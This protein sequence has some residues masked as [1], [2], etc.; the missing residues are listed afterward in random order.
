VHCSVTQRIPAEQ[1]VL[2][3]DYDN[4]IN[5]YKLCD[6]KSHLTSLHSSQEC[7]PPLNFYQQEQ[8]I[9]HACCGC[10]IAPDVWMY[11]S[12]LRPGDESLVFPT[13]SPYELRRNAYNKYVFMDRQVQTAPPPEDLLE[14]AD[15]S[16]IANG[17]D[18]EEEIY[19]M[20]LS[21]CTWSTSS[22]PDA[23]YVTEQLATLARC[24]VKVPGL[25]PCV[26]Q[27]NFSV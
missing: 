16:A 5:S 1:S 11:D 19:P 15:S 6:L 14:L 21:G 24:P 12:S 10:P 18:A 17:T 26:N 3:V 7:H 8:Q 27:D 13:Y 22:T 4:H 20:K 25:G 9:A 23:V 2:L